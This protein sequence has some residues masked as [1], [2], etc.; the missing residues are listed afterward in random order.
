MLVINPLFRNKDDAVTAAHK[1]NC[2]CNT[3]TPDQHDKTGDRA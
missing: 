1:C 3:G 2:I